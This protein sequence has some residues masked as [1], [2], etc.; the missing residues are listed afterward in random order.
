MGERK[1]N[2]VSQ[3]DIIPFFFSFYFIC[4]VPINGL[5]QV[6]CEKLRSGT[7]KSSTSRKYL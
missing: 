7:R 2:S 6:Y 1:R 4:G 5:Q 3:N